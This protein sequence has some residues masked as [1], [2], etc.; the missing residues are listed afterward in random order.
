MQTDGSVSGIGHTIVIS[1]GQTGAADTYSES[2][3]PS[4]VVD[5]LPVRIVPTYRTVEKS[6]NDLADL[7]GYTGRVTIDLAVQNLTVEPQQVSYDAG[8]TSHTTTA[9][10]GAPHTVVASASLPDTDPSTVVTVAK[11]ES[12]NGETTNGVLSRSADHGTQVQWATILAPPQLSATAT[13]RL[14]IDAKDF[15][16]PTVDIS[17]QPGLVTDPSVG[18]WSTLPSIR[19]TPTSWRWSREPSG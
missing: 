8:G 17:V 14:V 1:R 13:L 9:M 12:G 3:D 7:N 19:R 2:F 5:D 11:N 6:G 4:K 15:V 10:V 16:V 18:A